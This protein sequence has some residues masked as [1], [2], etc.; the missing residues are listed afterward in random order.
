MA[1]RTRLTGRASDVDQTVNDY[2][3]LWYTL[4]QA[5][6]PRV[7]FP[8]VPIP[9]RSRLPRVEPIVRVALQRVS[10]EA[11]RKGKHLSV[12]FEGKR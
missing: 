2:S 9:T 5:A 7:N 3:T 6:L 1:L 8:F 10:D 4:R 12:S 11:S